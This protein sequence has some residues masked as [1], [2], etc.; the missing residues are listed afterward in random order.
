MKLNLKLTSLLLGTCILACPTASAMMEEDSSD[1]PCAAAT[2]EST[3]EDIDPKI[4]EAYR[5]MLPFPSR[6]SSYRREWDKYR[7]IGTVSQAP[8]TQSTVYGDYEVRGGLVINA[9]KV[10]DEDRLSAIAA[11]CP[12]D[13]SELSAITQMVLSGDVNVIVAIGEFGEDLCSYWNV[14]PLMRTIKPCP[15]RTF[16]PLYTFYTG[17]CTKIGEGKGYTVYNVNFCEYRAGKVS[18]SKA[19][20]LYHYHDWKAGSFSRSKNADDFYEFVKKIASLT[21]QGKLKL[22]AHCHA[23]TSRTGVFLAYLKALLGGNLADIHT[24]GEAIEFAKKV[25]SELS[26]RR[27]FMFKPE[28]FDMFC[29]MLLGHLHLI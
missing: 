24:A 4:E 26:S 21:Q 22:L 5:S 25:V 18:R 20:P 10:Y 28:Q 6:R 13:I 1:R 7:D 2:A 17:K 12:R 9:T 3:A 19:I 14:D 29:R 8:G 23:G 11:Q 16:M 27:T 15:Q